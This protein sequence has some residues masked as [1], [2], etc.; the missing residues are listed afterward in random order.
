[1]LT[2]DAGADAHHTLI[3]ALHK[4]IRGSDVSVCV[5]GCVCVCGC[6]CLSWR[7]MKAYVAVACVCVYVCTCVCDYLGAS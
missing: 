3:S 4:S 2:L 5:G 1:M 6:V 7:Y